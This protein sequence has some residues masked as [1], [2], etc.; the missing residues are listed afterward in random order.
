MGQFDEG[1]VT[2][3]NFEKG[4]RF[5]RDSNT[6]Q[7]VFVHT[8]QLSSPIQLIDKVKYVINRRVN[9]LEAT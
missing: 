8:K 3:F 4:F 2:H 9:G 7:S 1:V 5:I 6:K